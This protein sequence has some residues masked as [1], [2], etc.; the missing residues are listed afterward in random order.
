M[1]NYK[2]LVERWRR[3]WGEKFSE[4]NLNPGFIK[5]YESGERIEVDFGYEKKRGR[6]GVSVGWWPVFILILRVNSAGSCHVIGKS[7]K[8]VRTISK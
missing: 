4:S 7:A 8:Y 2:K 5:F 1:N 3:K 6:V